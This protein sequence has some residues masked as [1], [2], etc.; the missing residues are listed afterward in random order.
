LLYLNLEAVEHYVLRAR[1]TGIVS[2]LEREPR[3][4]GNGAA[5]TMHK[6]LTKMVWR[7]MGQ[8]AELHGHSHDSARPSLPHNGHYLVEQV[9]NQGRFM[10]GGS[11]RWVCWVPLR[12]SMWGNCWR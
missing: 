8:G 7:D 10:H 9:G 6:V 5:C 12:R 3:P 4:L 2:D 1:V 11:P